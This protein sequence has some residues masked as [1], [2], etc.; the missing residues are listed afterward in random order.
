MSTRTT[1]YQ[2]LKPALT[3]TSDITAMNQ[4]WDTVDGALKS[5]SDSS[6][7][8]VIA[9]IRNQLNQKF[10]KAG[11]T[12]EGELKVP[13]PISVKHSA[14][15]GVLFQNNNGTNVGGMFVNVSNRTP[16]IKSFAS[17]GTNFYNYSVP[18]APSD[19]TKDEYH[20]F[21]TTKNAVTIGQGGTG[22]STAEQARSNLGA[23]PDGYGLGATSGKSCSNC[24]DAVQ[25]GWYSLSGSN[26]LNA[27]VNMGYCNMEVQRRWTK[28]WQIV[29]G[30]NASA[31]RI[32]NTNDS[33]ATWTFSEWEYDHPPLTAGT[34]YRTTERFNGKVVFAKCVYHKNT[35]AYGAMNSITEVSFP[36][37]ISGYGALV[38]VEAKQNVNFPLPTITSTGGSVSV[39]RV[40]ATNI[41]LRFANT[42]FDSRDWYITVYYTK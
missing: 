16:S 29:K 21:L 39:S 36:H 25:I 41:Y 3:D 5:L 1:N 38:R 6:G 22:A 40:D 13:S 10:P 23:A 15:S 18:A 19:L 28:V 20:T 7:A 9:D 11:G 4:N 42:A 24:N 32:G 31:I 12:L 17:N 26:V 27:P 2:L 37:G 14:N 35:S 30:D 8:A 33:G 34:E